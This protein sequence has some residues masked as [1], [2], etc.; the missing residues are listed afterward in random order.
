MTE[1]ATKTAGSDELAWANE[2][3]KK[4]NLQL[5]A[6]IDDHHRTEE[7]LRESE[8]KLRN[9]ISAE[10]TW[11]NICDTNGIIQEVNP[12]GIEIM[13]ADS[14]EDLI[15]RSFVEFVK[16]R[17]LEMIHHCRTDVCIGV[18][19]SLEVEVTT[20]KGN[21]RWLEVNTVLLPGSDNREVQIMSTIFDQTERKD[22]REQLLHQQA[23]LA[24]VMRLNTLGEMA[25]GLAHE[26]NQPLAAISNYLNGCERRINTDRCNK[27][28]ILEILGLALEQTQRA[29]DILNQV[30]RFLKHE[31]F[32]TRDTDLNEVIGGVVKLIQAAGQNA[33]IEIV[34]D[35]DSSLPVVTANHIQLEQVFINLLRNGI[36]AMLSA[37][38]IS[39][40][41]VIETH[42]ISTHK[43]SASVV[44]RGAGIPDALRESI[45]KPFFTTKKEGMG[46]GLA[47]C[48]SIIES[49]GGN[50]YIEN[51]EHGGGVVG[52]VL[53]IAGS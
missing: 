31:N 21:S 33:G 43:I 11:V 23:E 36:E 48:S 10:P 5:A 37:G 32:E 24:R 9:I 4:V 53:P 12:A 38:A 44:D 7:R 22:A 26:L 2:Q 3:L 8:E 18:Q 47:I 41:L 49:H 46:M 16:P 25:T 13:E 35:L 30:K 52:F 42:R 39:G 19:H 28:D 27:E 40:A 34:M 50:L 17:Y 15:G 45:F 1:D 51:R 29:G 6:E 14:S 20:L